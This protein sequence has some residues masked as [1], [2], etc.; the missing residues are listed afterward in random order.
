[1]TE[2][3]SNATTLDELIEEIKQTLEYNAGERKFIVLTNTYKE[4]TDNVQ[5]TF[6]FPV[7]TFNID[8]HPSKIETAI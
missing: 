6:S 1:M 2:I 4:I 5:T 7:P 3:K 8:T